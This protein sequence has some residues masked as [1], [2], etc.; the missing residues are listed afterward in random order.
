MQNLNF[1]CEDDWR[2]LQAFT[3]VITM[4]YKVFTYR[5]YLI[6]QVGTYDVKL[7]ALSISLFAYDSALESKTLSTCYS[8]SN[9]KFSCLHYDVRK[10]I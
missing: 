3:F 6:L 7:E 4:F 5:L 9:T 2:G 8:K 1:L 10:E